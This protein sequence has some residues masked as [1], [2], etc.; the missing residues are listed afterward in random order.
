M[1][2]EFS[3]G[4]IVYYPGQHGTEFLLIYAKATNYWG[5]PKGKLENNET[6]QQAAIRE[7]KEETGLDVKLVAPFEHTISYF[8]RDKKATLIKKTVY[9]YVGRAP[10]KQIVLSREHDEFVW[11]PYAEARSKITY[12]NDSE[13]FERA[14]AFLKSEQLNS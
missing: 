7:T 12:D 6:K 5:F 11:L 13:A 3:A 2:H 1:K 4:V 10:N 9:F 14:V 8:F